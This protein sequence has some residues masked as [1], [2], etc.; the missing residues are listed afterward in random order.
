MI[1][2]SIDNTRSKAWAI[3][4]KLQVGKLLHAITIPPDPSRK[5]GVP[6]WIFFCIGVDF[7][8]LERGGRAGSP[9]CQK[10]GG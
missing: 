3:S 10:I 9:S 7:C 1:Y 2:L 6:S 4:R 5:L 8:L